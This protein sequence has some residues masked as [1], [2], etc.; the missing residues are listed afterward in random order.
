M[1]TNSTYRSWPDALRG[2]TGAQEEARISN[3][4]DGAARQPQIV[5]AVSLDPRVPQHFLCETLAQ[6]LRDETGKSVLLVK[7][8][9]GADAL[10]F[11]AILGSNAN[12]RVSQPQNNG[13]I[14]QIALQVSARA[15]ARASAATLLDYLGSQ[16]DCVIVQGDL[17]E[18][19]HQSLLE[20]AGL[21]DAIYLF[22]VTTTSAVL[23]FSR[24]ICG[25]NCRATPWTFMWYSA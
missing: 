17:L 13:T 11:E 25:R 1:Q 16:F 5:V 9:P 10:T 15:E 21:A 8:T 7:L 18:T 12:A 19:P 24:P 6:S 3:V 14:S 23:N 2:S 20:F 22:L 4:A